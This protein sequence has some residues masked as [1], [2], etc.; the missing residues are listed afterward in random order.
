VPIPHP[1]ADNGPALVAAKAMAIVDDVVAALTG[2]ASDV[3]AAHRDRFQRLTQRRLQ[4]GA[5][6]LDDAC[7][8]DLA[9]TPQATTAQA[10]TVHAAVPL[11]R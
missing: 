6:C 5:L 3:A 10:A 2:D 9:L 4:D 8:T 7:A 1:L 11:A